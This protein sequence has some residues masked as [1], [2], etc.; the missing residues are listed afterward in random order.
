[1]PFLGVPLPGAEAKPVWPPAL[2][3]KPAAPVANLDDVQAKALL[4]AKSPA[5][6]AEPV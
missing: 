1:M 3:G 4:A 5:P 6:R 2:P